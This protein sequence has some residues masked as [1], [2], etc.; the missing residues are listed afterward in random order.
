MR[1][2]VRE[3]TVSTGEL[4]ITSVG[5]DEVVDDFSSMHSVQLS[6]PVLTLLLFN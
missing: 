3:S 4:V 5:E 6:P 2:G 1:Q